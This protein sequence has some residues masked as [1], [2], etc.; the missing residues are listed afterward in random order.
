MRIFALRNAGSLSTPSSVMQAAHAS[1]SSRLTCRRRLRSTLPATPLP[2]TSVASA[3]LSIGPRCARLIQMASMRPVG[4]AGCR[5]TTRKGG[6]TRN[7]ARRAA[8][9]AQD[10]SK[11][12]A[13]RREKA[14]QRIPERIGRHRLPRLSFPSLYT[15]AGFGPRKL[16]RNLL[17]AASIQRSQPS[18]TNHGW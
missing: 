3:T 14:N 11:C 16:R 1:D 12:M 2:V 8:E 15:N 6:Y 4:G 5:V 13:I 7:S 10:P 17:R 9:V 18:L